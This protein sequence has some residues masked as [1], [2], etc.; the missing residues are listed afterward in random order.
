MEMNDYQAMAH[1]TAIYP[2]NGQVQSL[3]YTGLGLAG[4][5]GELAGKLSKHFRG[6]TALNAVVK[7]DL[8]K[9]MGDVLWYLSEMATVLGVPLE[10][11][12][13]GNL[14][15]LGNRMSMGTIKGDGDGR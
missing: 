11:V 15:K 9:E 7:G 5:A 13:Q 8:V 3:Y 6:D 10:M 1:K 12:A 4:E 14:V 2:D